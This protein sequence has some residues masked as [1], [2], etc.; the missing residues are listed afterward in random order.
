[1]C[2]P[3]KAPAT[4]REAT[5]RPIAAFDL[6]HTLLHMLAAQHMPEEAKELSEDI[7]TFEVNDVEYGIALRV[8]TTALFEAL[9]KKGID[10]V[11]VTCNLMG[12]EI[13]E[14]LAARC[15]VFEDVPVHVIESREKGAKCLKTL[16]LK[17]SKVV[18]LDDSLN[19]WV[20]HD[21]EFVFEALRYDVQQLT[22]F[23]HEDSDEGDAKIDTE[24]G[25][26]TSIRESLL[27][28]FDVQAIN[29]EDDAASEAGSETPRSASFSLEA[30]PA[31]S[32]L[33]RAVSSDEDG[34]AKRA[35]TEASPI[36]T[37]ADNGTLNKPVAVGGAPVSS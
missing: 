32:S 5:E 22:T 16:G 19:A 37:L 3:P 17:R 9:R 29:F 21:Q 15:D 36:P 7:V 23:L 30:S 28:F 20:Q 27:S 6:D 1:M 4:P 10:I 8:G 11:V 33:K 12:D 26:M 18:I 14:A 2:G 24:L 25:Y 31:L 13:L 35:R 34:G